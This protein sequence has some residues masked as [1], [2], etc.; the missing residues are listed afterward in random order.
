MC[1]AYPTTRVHSVSV[2]IPYPRD[3][4]GATST[5]TAVKRY[6]ST[7]VVKDGNDTEKNTENSKLMGKA[8]ETPTHRVREHNHKKKSVRK[9]V[10][11]GSISSFRFVFLI[12]KTN[13]PA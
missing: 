6:Y 7:N 9:A 13:D 8:S 2:L 5:T 12:S 1:A 11:Y 10:S 3:I 4:P